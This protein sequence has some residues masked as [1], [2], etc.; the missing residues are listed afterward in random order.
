MIEIYTASLSVKQFWK[1]KIKRG[2]L[3]IVTYL[4]VKVGKQ[5]GKENSLQ[6]NNAL[7]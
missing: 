3:P 2:I 1:W 7:R 5:G 4:A 6:Q